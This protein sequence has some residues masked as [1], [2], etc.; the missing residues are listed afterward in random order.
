MGKEV[1]YF[2]EALDTRVTATIG[3]AKEKHTRSY[4]Q[5]RETIFTNFRINKNNASNFT[6]ANSR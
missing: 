4:A 3:A 6:K 1:V 2:G 5:D